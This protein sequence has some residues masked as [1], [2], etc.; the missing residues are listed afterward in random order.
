MAKEDLSGTLAVILH[1]DVVGST[2]LV[3]QD[4]RLAHERIRDSFQRISD[5]VK[6]YNGQVLELRGDALIAEFKRASDAVSASLT[7][8]TDQSNYIQ[9]L[10]D[11]LRPEIRA[12]IAMGEII[13]ADNTVTG[14]GVV[15]HRPGN[16]VLRR[17]F[18][19]LHR[20]PEHV[21]DGISFRQPRT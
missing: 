1:A 21:P 20:V 15:H 3:Q 9:H 12:G 19:R 2:A 14:A 13:I 11:D 10:E 16:H 7:F 18:L 8:Q 5:T 17:P 4:K 6:K